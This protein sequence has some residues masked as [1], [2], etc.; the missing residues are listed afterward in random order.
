ME[1]RIRSDF[2][3]LAALFLELRKESATIRQIAELCITALQKGNKILFCGNGGSAADAQH[4]AAELMGRYKLN[5]A[6]LPAIA[7]TTDTS[8]LTAVSNDYGYE[9]VFKRQ[10]EG[11]GRPGDVLFGITTSG[12]SPNVLAAVAT[13][14]ALGMRTVGMTGSTGGKLAELAELTLCVPSTTANT[15]QEM[16][17]AVGHLLCDLIES[18]LFEQGLLNRIMP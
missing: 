6:A 14:G 18:A 9:T 8:I 5:R 1:D 11:L 7:L 13:A 12:G 3:K 2:E 16:H 4:L 10:V 17:I 15:I